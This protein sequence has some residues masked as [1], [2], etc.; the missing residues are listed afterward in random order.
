MSPPDERIDTD[1]A[2]RQLAK[3]IVPVEDAARTALRRDRLVPY[4]G[5]FAGDVFAA[6]RRRQSIRLF[7][8]LAAVVAVTVLGVV[9]FVRVPRVEQ[10]AASSA[11]VRTKEGAVRVSRPGLPPDAL[12]RVPFALGARDRVETREGRAE[13]SLV[14]GAIVDLE[15]MSTL[16]LGSGNLDNGVVDEELDLASG[17]ISVRV[18]KL[19][20]KGRLSVDTPNARVT[21]HG[22][23][24]VVE[25]LPAGPQGPAVTRVSV[26][27]GRVSVA[28][29]GREIFLGPGANW[30]S[31]PRNE[32]VEALPSPEAT[33][34]PSV[35]ERTRPGSP[36]LGDRRAAVPSSTLA[37]ENELFRSALAARRRGDPGRAI[38]LLDHLLSGYK[39]SPL[40][41]EARAERARAVL[42]LE[43]AEKP[44]PAP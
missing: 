33:P 25:V 40:V 28:S 15:P 42:D 41:A 35:A 7:A 37:E 34:Q 11:S 9:G 6:R 38:E 8:A 19:G 29:G 30:S 16:G 12:E 17:R 20:A 18:P 32:Q 1:R 14:S 44:S 10:A 26:T 22:T 3:S 43:H 39:T 24:F 36:S 4:L 23:V 31:A 5:A 21:V 13:V 2:L 27:E